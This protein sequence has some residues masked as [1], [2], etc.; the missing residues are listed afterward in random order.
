MQ[1]TDTCD[2]YCRSQAQNG[3]I[4]ANP[5][6]III[7]HHA[8]LLEPAMGLEW[9]CNDAKDEL[10]KEAITREKLQQRE[11]IEQAEIG[12]RIKRAQILECCY[13]PW[14]MGDIMNCGGRSDAKSAPFNSCQDIREIF[15]PQLPI[16]LCARQ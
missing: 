11:G 6:K 1:R 3:F 14:S 2:Y 12:A 5:L 8:A 10:W 4:S 13:Q 9:I 7:D 16:D 15:H